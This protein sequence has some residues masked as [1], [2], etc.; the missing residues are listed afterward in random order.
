MLENLDVAKYI[1][2]ATQGVIAYT[3]KVV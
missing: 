2:F 1:D 3:P